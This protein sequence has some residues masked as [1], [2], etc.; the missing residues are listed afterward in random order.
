MQAR[1]WLRSPMRDRQTRP[2]QLQGKMLPGC[3]C[4]DTDLSP[5][6]LLLEGS[7]TNVLKA[8]GWLVYSVTP[9]P[10]VSGKGWPQ[11]RVNVA[12]WQGFLESVFKSLFGA[13]LSRCPVESLPYRTILGRQWSAILKTCPAQHSCVF[14]SMA[15]IL[16]IPALSSTS[17]FVM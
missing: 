4:G 10:S 15:L 12:C 6:S 8:G 7:S 5:T 3:D 1:S 14:I 17:T 13:P 11:L 9:S 16:V 2:Q